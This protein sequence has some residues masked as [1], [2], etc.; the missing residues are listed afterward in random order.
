MQPWMAGS[1][2][3]ACRSTD[4]GVPQRWVRLSS[5]RRQPHVQR[6]VNTQL[7]KHGAQE[8]QALQPLCRVAVACEAEAQQ[9]LA[10]CAHGLE[11][12]FVH[13]STVR[14]RLRDG[15]RGRPRQDAQPAPVTSPLEGTLASRLATRQARVDQ[16]RCFILATQARD[17]VRVPPQALLESDKGPGHAERGVRFLTD[18]PL[19][20]SS[21]SRKTPARLMALLMVMTVCLL[22]YAALAYRLRTALKEQDATCPHQQG[23]PVQHP[24]ARWVFQDFVGIHVLRIPGQWDSIVLHLTEGHQCLLPLLGKPSTRLYR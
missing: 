7:R 14:S 16:H 1:R 12:T 20:A 22:V 8:V 21:C 17:D 11:A 3:P 23:Q 5:E 6:T 24:T 2:D 15:Q 13:E 4:G 18:P 9:A 19:L 10:T